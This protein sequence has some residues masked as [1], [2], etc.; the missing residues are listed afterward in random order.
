MLLSTRDI[1]PMPQWDQASRTTIIES[2]PWIGQHAISTLQ[3]SSL[4]FSNRF[5][6]DERRTTG[7]CLQDRHD[8]DL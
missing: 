5:E 4:F 1:D 7:H 3:R 2:Q 8:P 6:S